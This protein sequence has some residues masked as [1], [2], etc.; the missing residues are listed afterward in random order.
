MTS[1]SCRPSVDFCITTVLRLARHVITTMTD[2]KRI[3]VMR[4]A[5]A[6]R[7]KAEEFGEL[8]SV[9]HEADEG[10]NAWEN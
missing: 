5:D 6:I 4:H 8:A 3:P 10:K 2:T 1:S 9:P 7:S